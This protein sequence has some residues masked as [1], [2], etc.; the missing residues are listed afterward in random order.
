MPRSPEGHDFENEP[1][2]PDELA[3][4]E[5]RILRWK[6]FVSDL[7]VAEILFSL[8][9]ENGDIFPSSQAPYAHLPMKLD[10]DNEASLSAEEVAL[11]KVRRRKRQ[12]ISVRTTQKG[13][14]VTRSILY[15]ASF[16]PET[17]VDESVEN[18]PVSDVTQIY[19]HRYLIP[20]FGAGTILRHEVTKFLK[21]EAGKPQAPETEANS[22]LI[23]TPEADNLIADMYIFFW[24]EIRSELT[25]LMELEE[26]SQPNGISD[27]LS[28][29][30]RREILQLIFTQL[31]QPET[32]KWFYTWY[33]LASQLNVNPTVSGTVWTTPEHFY[34]GLHL[35]L[36]EQYVLP[37]GKYRASFCDVRIP[38]A[39]S[40]FI[41][42][43]DLP[44]PVFRSS[45]EFEHTRDYYS[46]LQQSDEL[47]SNTMQ[48]SD[49]PEVWNREVV[50][51]IDHAKTALL[52]NEEEPQF[53]TFYEVEVDPQKGEY[54]YFSAR[55]LPTQEE[56]PSGDW[57]EHFVRHTQPH[58]PSMEELL[59]LYSLLPVRPV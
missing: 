14:E 22:F 42:P 7:R 34:A 6:H 10:S 25:F 27:I 1:L 26:R 54:T 11:S 38:A 52:H 15:S 5:L 53:G 16:S 44:Y 37:D 13:F 47:V 24:Q 45:D 57:H 55:V 23:G 49:D 12:E 2:S 20:F 50:Q 30:K 9:Q 18:I 51:R 31:A 4:K 40:G 3:K 46:M 19:E 48:S 8:P 41:G 58:C 43:E 28:A 21:N 32:K 17:E 35:N 39:A 36:R 56:T 33:P 29:E 59:A